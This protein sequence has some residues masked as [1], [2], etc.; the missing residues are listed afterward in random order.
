MIRSGLLALSILVLLG[1]SAIPASVT[2][3]QPNSGAGG[4]GSGQLV[5][6]SSP[7]KHW[8]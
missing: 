2:T 1:A 7:S 3:R 4:M 8:S 6:R 5:A